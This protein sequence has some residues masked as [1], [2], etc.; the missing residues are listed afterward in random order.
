MHRYTSQ[1]ISIDHIHT[2][3]GSLVSSQGLLQLVC[4]IVLHLHS[5]NRCKQ[6]WSL[7]PG[8]HSHL[9]LLQEASLLRTQLLPA[10]TQGFIGS[11]D[12]GVENPTLPGTES[13]DGTDGVDQETAN[14]VDNW[15]EGE[16]PPACVSFP[17]GLVS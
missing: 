5:G 10:G 13:T 6:S 2:S 8:D 7:A 17:S 15:E 16:A 3:A 4:S 12:P 1:V 9:L 11:E 14:H